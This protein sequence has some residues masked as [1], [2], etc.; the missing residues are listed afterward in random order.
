MPSDSIDNIIDAFP[1]ATL[2]RIEGIPTFT[3]IRHMQVELNSN[4]ASI[5]SNL[6]DGQLGHLY[7]T[8]SPTVYATLSAQ[9]FLIPENPG[10]LPQIPGNA[11]SRQATD[12]RATY[13]EE[14]RIFNQYISTDKA[15]KSQII[16]AV[17]DLY[18]KA[19]KHR[20]TG[21]ANV[22]TRQMLD[23]LY[24][25]YGTLTPQDLQYVDDEMKK[26]YDPY[27]PIET[28]Y[29]QIE[30][31]VDIASTAGAPY[32]P[33]QVIN[34]AYTIVYNT[35]VFN[36]SCRDWRKKQE[37]QKTWANFKTHFTEAHLDF[38]TY[39]QPNP[40]QSANAAI[41]APTGLESEP[42]L[43]DEATIALANLAT[44]T[45]ADRS[46]MAALS[47]TNEHL[48]KQLSDVTTQ[49]TLALNK[50]STLETSI[51]NMRCIPVRNNPSQHPGNANQPTTPNTRNYCWT[52]GFKVGKNHT[53]QTCRNPKEGHQREATSTNMM[54][55]STMGINSTN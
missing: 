50:I 55:G 24:A 8:I 16:Q 13:T 36:D 6:G 49:L 30:N 7:L 21:Y 39:N 42:Q 20:I 33:K 31:A 11:T 43:N 12:L 46:A 51:T 29:D 1:H 9:E 22:T 47:T 34:I 23:H 52:H 45:A 25:S 5:H 27:S 32:A 10:A 18:L 17:D 19:L 28:L 48:V 15:L 4:S 3:T 53:S 41:A 14:K 2:T 38:R 44:A 40:Y 26:Q 37:L 54:G 35:N